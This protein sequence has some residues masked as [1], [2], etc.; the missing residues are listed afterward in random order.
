M[1]RYNTFFKFTSCILKGAVTCFLEIVCQGL[2]Q[3]LT[4][5]QVRPIAKLAPH[6]QKY[7]PAYFV[8]HT[9]YVKRVFIFR[10]IKENISLNEEL[11]I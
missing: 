7:L 1:L 5:E 2:V 9:D 11:F 6:V 10:A 3:H 4:S 8:T